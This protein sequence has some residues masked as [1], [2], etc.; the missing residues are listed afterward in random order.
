[1]KTKYL[2]TT[3]LATAL[4]TQA[5]AEPPKMKMTSEIPTEYTAPDSVETSIGK[6]DYFDG[7]PSPET[8]KN[9]YD[10]LDTSRAVN[11]YLNSIPALSVNALREGQKAM[12]ADACHKICIWDNLMD[13]KT[14]LLTGNTSTRY[15][16]GFLD[17][18]KD[19]P[20]VIDL[21]QGMLGI[22]D[23]MAFHYMVDLGVAGPDKGKGGK[24][25]V[26]PPG[27]KGDVPEGYFV[28]PSKTS[29]VWVFMR[30][31]LDKSMPIEKAVPA[32]SKNIRSTLKVYPLSA[33][34]TPR[35]PSSSTCPA[36]TC[37]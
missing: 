22:L 31:Y 6:L 2:L 37:T 17:L 4:A 25:L 1:M 16:V 20:T 13:S 36:R 21:P 24:Y 8:V 3:A 28:V 7:V 27:Y 34:D 14:I 15:A 11:V 9:V 19:G 5:W 18:I 30:G 35:S 29:G 12:G 32:A 10:Y 33:A 26:L 23:D